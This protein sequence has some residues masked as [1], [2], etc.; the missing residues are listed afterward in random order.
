[1]TVLSGA[2]GGGLA[3]LFA[4]QTQGGYPHSLA[5]QSAQGL[6]PFPGGVEIRGADG[7]TVLDKNARELFSRRLDYADL[8][9]DSAFGRGLIADRA[10]GRYFMHNKKGIMFE[11]KLQSPITLVAAGKK[12]AGLVSQ[13]VAGETRIEVLNDRG[14][15]IFEWSRAGERI[16]SV[17]LSHNGRYAAISLLRVEEGERLCRVVIFNVKNGKTVSETDFSRSTLIRVRFTEAG[18][19][20]VLGEGLL[21][22]LKT[23]GS[24]NTDDI[25]FIAG[26]LER[27]AF[28]SGGRAALLLRGAENERTLKVFDAYGNL[29]FE[30]NADGEILAL[31]LDRGNTAALFADSLEIYGKKGELSAKVQTGT[32]PVTAL[33][34]NGKSAYLLTNAA[35]EKISF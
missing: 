25:T 23:N 13:T 14:H 19:L 26:Q 32:A 11:G 28:S 7:V 22:C 33:C 21:A 1:M 27:F 10:D 16:S 15:R 31:A 30:K 17:S 29:A 35:V 4:D 34:L 9:A 8:T 6:L 3:A 24:R 18:R 12:N 5:V 20:Y 2:S